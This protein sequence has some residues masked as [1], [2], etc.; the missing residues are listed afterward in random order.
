[1]FSRSQ[2]LEVGA[3]DRWIHR[4]LASGEW[5]QIAEGVY[6]LAAYPD[7]AMSRLW[8]TVLA[9]TGLSAISHEAAATLHGLATFRS[10]E[11]V[12]T[13]RHSRSRI[14]HLA[15][16]HQSR[17][18]YDE[19]ITT[20]RGLPVTTV[21]RT[22]IDLAALFR[23]ARLEVIVDDALA[24]GN[25]KLAEL[26]STFDDLAARGRK[27]TRLMRIILEARLPG[28][29]APQSRAES[30]M[31]RVLRE[32]GL[33][34]PVLQFPHPSPMI[35]SYVDGAY[36]SEQILIEIDSRRWHT[37][38]ARIENDKE[39]DQA[40]NLVDWDTYRFTWRD[41]TQR[42]GWVVSQ[43]RKALRKAA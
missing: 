43:L 20:V 5:V 18:L 35:D 3:S 23:R 11:P 38:M 9:P 27:G 19:H 40:A 37:Q 41:L 28:Y 26:A 34:R 36:V 8:A 16:V 42:P 29:V 25:V 32:G 13:V 2:V 24:S 30:L 22:L 33:P 31:L 39:R 1:V 21:A 15:T 7:T 12:V 4:R 10:L 14:E 6:R 17:R